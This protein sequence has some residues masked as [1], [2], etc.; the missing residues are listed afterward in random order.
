MPW[1]ERNYSRTVKAGGEAMVEMM[2]DCFGAIWNGEEKPP[3]EW[4]DPSAV[5]LS[6]YKNKGSRSDQSNYSSIFLLDVVGKLLAKIINGRLSR[7][8]KEVIA[9]SQLGFRKNLSTEHA[10]S[11][12]LRLQYLNRHGS[13]AMC[14]AFVD[15]EKAFDIVP[16]ELIWETLSENGVGPKMLSVIKEFHEEL[17]GTIKGTNLSFLMKRGVR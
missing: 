3:K 4:A 1:D 5:S 2:H 6:I 15:L 17:E 10:M 8:V 16:R 14:A 11:A 13:R 9:S 12:V 7:I